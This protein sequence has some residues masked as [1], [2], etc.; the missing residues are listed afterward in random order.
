[1]SST[2]SAHSRRCRSQHHPTLSNG[3][4]RP[5]PRR[6][7]HPADVAHPPRRIHRRPQAGDPILHHRPGNPT[8]LPH[9][10]LGSR[11]PP[12]RSHRHHPRHAECRNSRRNPPNRTPLES[13]PPRRG[14]RP[15]QGNRQA[16]AQPGLLARPRAERSQPRPPA[17]RK[18]PACFPP[19]PRFHP[20][21][22]PLLA[23]HPAPRNRPP[24]GQHQRPHRIHAPPRPARRLV[25][26]PRPHRAS[27][28]SHSTL[29]SR[30]PRRHGTAHRR[31]RIPAGHRRKTQSPPRQSRA[32]P[33]P[34]PH[35]PERHSPAQPA[36]RPL[37][38]HAKR[39]RRNRGRP[40]T[41]EPIR[42]PRGRHPNPRDQHRL[43]GSQPAE[44]PTEMVG[45]QPASKP[46]ARRLAA[47]P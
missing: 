2:S 11:R 35:H 3:Q 23:R 42:H 39:P 41:F 7:R 26:T 19:H 22:G 37:G 46:L 34:A 36:F 45:R 21:T 33:R 29:Q 13:R 27:G 32:V 47:P 14:R 12:R 16:H 18:P 1:M 10:P 31:T 17:K 15:G 43:H 9:R 40:H 25:L 20:A 4:Q 44:H 30:R 6:P 28:A 24:P 8:P 38:R 5:H